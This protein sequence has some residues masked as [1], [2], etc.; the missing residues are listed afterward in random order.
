MSAD[1]THTKKAAKTRAHAQPGAG[2]MGIELK[3]AEIDQDRDAQ[4]QHGLAVITVDLGAEVKQHG[5]G[6]SRRYPL[7]HGLPAAS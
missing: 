6:S 2:I 3:Q 5:N 4:T 7:P 1:Q